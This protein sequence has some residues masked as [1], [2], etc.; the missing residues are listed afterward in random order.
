[1]GQI[2]P[3]REEERLMAERAADWLRRLEDGDVKERAA[4]MA[5]LKESPRHVREVLLAAT[6]DKV[7]DSLDPEKRIDIGELT[8]KGANTVALEPQAAGPSRAVV[9]R[10]SS[11]YNRVLGLVAALAA[12]T[13]VAFW[14]I[15]RF[16][17]TYTTAIGEQRAIELADGSVIHLNARSKVKVDLSKS[18]RQIHLVEGQALFNVTQDL[19]R[20]FIV[21][22]DRALIQA[23]GT[24][25]DVHRRADRT[26]VA[27]IE[28][29]IKV[30]TAEAGKTFPAIL[31]SQNATMLN[32]GEATSVTAD[33]RVH[34]RV[35]KPSAV[36]VSEVTA[37][38]QRRLVF[39]KDTLADIAAE[40][41][42]YNRVP[43]LRV[44]G[45]TLQSRPFNGVF[46]ADDPES[47]IRFLE[48]VDDVV[49]R[50]QGSE[51]V[52]MRDRSN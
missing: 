5:W 4:F 17:H 22:V 45:E 48:G 7:L 9:R 29:R 6:W 15:D 14:G 51:V 52:I 49:V 2:G 47:L 11:S 35:M 32:A 12:V 8:A 34:E 50:R 27:V 41:N 19:V 43:Q 1:M 36:D 10:A 18:A 42:R 21:H 24:Q 28:G 13:L 20:P 30:A 25:F 44:E 26:T 33:G 23:I 38:R 16:G 37:W 40:F 46:D 31:E 39:R 3:H